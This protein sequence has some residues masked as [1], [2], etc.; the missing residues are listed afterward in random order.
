MF[1]D[2]D[3]GVADETKMHRGIGPKHIYVS[4]LER[5]WS[6]GQSLVIYHTG[7]HEPT[8]DRIAE[9]RGMLSDGLENAE[10]TAPRFRRG[11]GSALFAVAE[12]CHRERIR[13]RTLG[14]LAG[15]WEKKR[16]L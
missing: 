12:P 4:D 1:F 13:E 6:R 10:I 5:F 16:P 9:V 3:N 15:P 11:T 2:P 14:L 8:D 7:A